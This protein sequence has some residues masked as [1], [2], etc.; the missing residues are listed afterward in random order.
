[1]PYVEYNTCYPVDKKKKV[2]KFKPRLKYL[3]FKRLS[4]LGRKKIASRLGRELIQM[5][6]DSV[7]S[8]GPQTSGFCSSAKIFKRKIEGFNI[9][10]SALSCQAQMLKKSSLVYQHHCFIHKRMF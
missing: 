1:M 4:V 7:Q 6:T 10:L 5:I 8:S 2:I 3:N 9:R